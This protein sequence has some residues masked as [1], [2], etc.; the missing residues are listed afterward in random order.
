MHRVY[1]RSRR[2]QA[3]HAGLRDEARSAGGL[4]AVS[5]RPVFLAA[6]AGDRPIPVSA[7]KT[8]SRL[9]TLKRPSRREVMPNSSRVVAR[10]NFTPLR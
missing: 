8:A 5:V 6:I 9:E 2:R 1:G 7:P 3:V 4:R 10:V